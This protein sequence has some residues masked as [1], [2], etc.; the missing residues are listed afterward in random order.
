M[1]EGLG[2]G[3]TNKQ[4]AIIKEQCRQ[5]CFYCGSKKNLEVDHLIPESR[6][7]DNKLKNGVAACTTC[8]REK[9]DKT[10]AEY[11]PGRR[12]CEGFVKAT[13]IYEDDGGQK[14]EYH[15]RCEKYYDPQRDNQKYCA[16]HK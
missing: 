16:D 4:K 14:G 8:N 3:F 12:R 9:G 15:Y 13:F 6:G 10:H 5:K 11:K 2:R 7:G 1:Y